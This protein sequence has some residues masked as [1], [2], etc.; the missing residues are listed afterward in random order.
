MHR[1][2]ILQQF[3][4]SPKGPVSTQMHL[5]R[6]WR[7]QLRFWCLKGNAFHFSPHKRNLLTSYL[8]DPFHL[9]EEILIMDD[10]FMNMKITYLLHNQ[11]FNWHIISLPMECE[12]QIW[13]HVTDFSPASSWKWEDCYFAKGIRKYWIQILYYWSSTYCMQAKD[14]YRIHCWRRHACYIEAQN[15]RGFWTNHYSLH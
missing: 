11:T 13:N 7:L 6:L 8:K 15:L 14:C 9:K 4:L 3:K 12:E 1:H 10:Y 5:W 2:F